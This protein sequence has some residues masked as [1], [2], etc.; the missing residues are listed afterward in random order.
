MQPT[1]SARLYFENNAGRLLEHADGYVVF[2]YHPGKR[3]LADLQALL[4]HTSNLLNRN[5]WHRL[6]GDQRLMSP[7]TEEE[8]AWIKTYWLDSSLQRP[9]GIYGAIILAHD[10]FARLAMNQVMH[11]AKASALTYRLFETEETAVA[12]LRQL[13]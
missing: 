2:Q 8:S 13:R 10:V 6:L 7:F 4:T 9:G 1:A 11:E 3:N 5:Q 12:W